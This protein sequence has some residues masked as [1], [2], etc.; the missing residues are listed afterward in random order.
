MAPLSAEVLDPVEASSM[1]TERGPEGA[2]RHFALH[3]DYANSKQ[4]GYRTLS[5][6]DSTGTERGPEGTERHAAL[7]RNYAISKQD[8]S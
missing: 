6:A 4:D 5:L 2:E 8:G 1:G 3:K 7:H